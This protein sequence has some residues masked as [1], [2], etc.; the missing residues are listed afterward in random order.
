M[1]KIK[2][3]I[4][5]LTDHN[6]PS[7]NELE[8]K[9]NIKRIIKMNYNENLFGCSPKVNEWIKVKN[10]IKGFIYPDMKPKKLLDSISKYWNV[11][12]DNIMIANGS[13]AI[14]DL[15]PRVFLDEK[16]EVIVTDLTYGRHANTAKI[17]GNKVNIIKQL[18]DY[19]YD[20]NSI[21]NAINSNTKIIYITNPNMP[22]G[23]YINQKE[24]YDFVEK[25][26]KN[27][28]LVIDEAYCEFANANDFPYKTSELIKTHDNILILHTFSKFFG[29]SGFRIG[30]ALSS[31]YLIDAMKKTYQ[32]LSTNKYAIY[33]ATA[34]IND[35]QW[36]SDMKA[37]AISEKEYLYNEFAKLNLNFIK[38]QGNYIFLITKEEKWENHE[39]RMFLL[40]NY[41]ICIRNVR[42]IGLRL[43]IG[44]HKQNQI[45]ISGIKAFLNKESEKNVK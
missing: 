45:L 41:S 31:K 43:T 27:I 26:P 39:L 14:I 24:L 33:A 9:H 15:I 37:K 44:N 12:N 20:L 2:K 32:P 5:N 17:T 38:S 19:N 22:T 30:Y 36:Y 42:T 7:M 1:I 10:D 21:L 8:K 25:V 18:E 4:I 6:I 28:L 35:R 13:D 34:A 11:N 40:V 29:L 3:E 23:T 16:D